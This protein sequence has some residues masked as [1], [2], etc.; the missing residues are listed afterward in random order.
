MTTELLHRVKSGDD[1]ALERLLERCVPA[2]RRWAHG[3]LPTYARDMLETQDLVQEAVIAALR[4][5]QAFESRHHGALQA[6]LRQSVKNR[7]LDVIRQHQRRPVEVGLSEHLVDQQL[8]PLDAAIG[9]ENTERYETALQRL[10]PADREAIIGRLELGY[11]Y[12]ELA[13]VLNKPSSAAARMA[14]NRG[15]KRLIAEMHRAAR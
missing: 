9:S 4:N 3:R 11:S 2:L 15:I 10:L 1:A 5:L 6:Y 8:S 13:I 12:E 7:V 14:V